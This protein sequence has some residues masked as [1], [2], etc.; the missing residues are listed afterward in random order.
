[1]FDISDL[2]KDD[3]NNVIAVTSE[4]VNINKAKD[5]KVAFMPFQ[6]TASGV[7]PIVIVSAHPQGT[8]ETRNFVQKLNTTA[9]EAGYNKS[10]YTNF[11][12]DGVSYESD[13]VR[14]SI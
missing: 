13:D 7:P 3:V 11:C 4:S 5:F 6:S 2:P 1:M 12:V 10:S 14:K 8:N 9:V